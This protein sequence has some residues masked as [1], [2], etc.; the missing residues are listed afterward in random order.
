[1]VNG[2]TSWCHRRSKYVIRFVTALI[3]AIHK[4]PKPDGRER[5]KLAVED[6][7]EERGGVDTESRL[8]LRCDDRHDGDAA[9]R[10]S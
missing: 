3:H 10:R 8:A 4:W 6:A 2:F 9:D 5:R 1:M 7:T